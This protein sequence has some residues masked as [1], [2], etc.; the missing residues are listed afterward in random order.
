M[1]P[2]E[3]RILDDIEQFG[4]H[5]TSVFDPDQAEPSF[6][7]SI[8]L[9][10]SLGIPEVIVVGVRPEL[11]HA[12][13]NLY[14]DRARSGESFSLGIPYPGF[15]TGFS[16]YFRQVIEE[17]RKAFMLSAN[18]LYNGT[19]YSAL[20]IVYPTTDGV[21]PWEPAATDWFRTNQPMLDGVA[22]GP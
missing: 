3:Q 20:Q 18:W 15:L 10:K 7:Y 13:I 21:W 11:G 17:N 14:M 5:V 19:D 9:T 6:S 16:V 8:G 4:C 1:K 2:A 12:L 22:G